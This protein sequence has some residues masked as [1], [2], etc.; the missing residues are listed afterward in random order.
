MK[1]VL[2]SVKADYDLVLLDTLAAF[3]IMTLNALSAST[4]V[5]L[6]AQADILSLNAL[7]DSY[8]LIQSAR[9]NVNAVLKIYGVLLTRVNLRSKT[10]MQIA[11]MFRDAA[12]AMNTRVFNSKIR[13]SATVRTAQALQRDILTYR[14]QGNAAKDYQAFINE[15][16][17][18]LK[19]EGD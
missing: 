2:E 3:D 10:A 11:D 18:I 5:I 4:G 6:P 9:E 12:E 14:P 1:G 17:V 19:S 13:E 8:D 15:L 7:K 16:D